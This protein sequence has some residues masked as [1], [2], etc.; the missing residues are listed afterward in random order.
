MR[1][2][3]GLVLLALAAAL[4]VLALV[5]VALTGEWER[6]IEA[7]VS[8]GL[9]MPVDATLHGRPALL[10][11]LT[12]GLPR[13]T[14][15][16]TGPGDRAATRAVRDARAT[17]FDVALVPGRP[18]RWSA[19]RGLARIEAEDEGLLGVGAVDIR[20]S[21]IRGVEGDYRIAEVRAAGDGEGG[22]RLELTLAGVEVESGSATRASGRAASGTL[23]ARDPRAELPVAGRRLRVRFR[24]GAADWRP[25]ATTLTAAELDVVVQE[26][27]LPGAD[28]SL[29]R[30]TATLP[31]ARLERGVEE[32]LITSD[33][34]RV[35]AT[36]DQEAIDALWQFPG[37]V[38]LLEGRARVS[39]GGASLDVEV[40][41]AG[42]QVE[43]RPVVPAFLQVLVGAVPPLRFTPNLPEGTVLERVTVRPGRLV[44]E[45]SAR[46]VI[47]P[48]P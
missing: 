20:L 37:D 11:A 41:A 29:S 44:L 47:L 15:D 35:T 46:R 18:V 36:V 23:A 3:L 34:G 38:E 12:T 43:L 14:I 7:D 32:T 31:G 17:L 10:R 25:E 1:S 19:P 42:G 48:Q 13:V 26:L 6:R 2:R 21:D 30:V 16:A 45:G 8:A 28:A 24:D 5:D 4:V 33:A 39:T 9:G 27:P 22:Q 40:S